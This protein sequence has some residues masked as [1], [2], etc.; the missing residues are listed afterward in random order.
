M[1]S[2]HYIL[3]GILKG[4][5]E[6]ARIVD[7]TE[8]R[9]SVLPFKWASLNLRA[10]EGKET[11]LANFLNKR[12]SSSRLITANRTSLADGSIQ[13]TYVTRPGQSVNEEDYF[14]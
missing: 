6:Y 11:D 12:S 4:I 13:L 9:L 8:P 14:I 7:H 10:K 3:H 2:N 5:E 1:D